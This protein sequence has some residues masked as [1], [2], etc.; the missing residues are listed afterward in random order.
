MKHSDK[1]LLKE[2]MRRLQFLSGIEPHPQR[3]ESTT[4][5]TAP[6]PLT[7]RYQPFKRRNRSNCYV[8]LS[9]C[10]TLFI[11]NLHS[12]QL[13]R[14][15]IFNTLSQEIHFSWLLIELNPQFE[16]NIWKS[17]F[18]NAK[19]KHNWLTNVVVI[20]GNNKKVLY[21]IKPAHILHS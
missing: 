7:S 18:E 21:C 2:T 5:T 11:K 3:W 14:S 6:I 13:M 1:P 8:F 4:L 10:F 9:L 19:I 12:L 20:I 15:L 17:T 16:W